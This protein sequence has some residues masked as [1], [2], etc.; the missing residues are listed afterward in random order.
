[1]NKVVSTIAKTGVAALI[2]MLASC[3]KS[4][5]EQLLSIQEDMFEVM[6]DV[7][8]LSSADKAAKEI[9][10]LR[11]KAGKL[12]ESVR[13]KLESMSPEE[14]KKYQDRVWGTLMKGEPVKQQLFNKDC[15]VSS[16][17]R[18]ALSGRLDQEYNS[19]SPF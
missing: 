15:Y 17:L 8:D 7:K 4:E 13:E 10:K 19:N 12:N 1:M 6:Q 16:E 14:K 3:Q 2:F 11:E 5:P 18:K 9:F